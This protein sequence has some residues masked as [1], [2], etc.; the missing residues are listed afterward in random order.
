MGSERHW[1]CRPVAR[2]EG[3]TCGGI[4]P[5]GI[6]SLS[7]GRY[8]GKMVKIYRNEGSGS[9]NVEKKIVKKKKDQ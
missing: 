4:N 3:T 1:F 8:F 7:G 6:R 5:T 2:V 9:F